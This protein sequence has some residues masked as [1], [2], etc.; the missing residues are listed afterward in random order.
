MGNDRAV[1]AKYEMI[2]NNV[3]THNYAAKMVKRLHTYIVITIAPDCLSS[4][5]SSRGWQTQ[6]C[7]R[8]EECLDESLAV[9]ANS[10]MVADKIPANLYRRDAY[11]S[12]YPEIQ[13]SRL[14]K[15]L[16]CM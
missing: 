4:V 3:F 8:L 13:A 7:H 9:T 12:C 10:E 1:G 5:L 15:T 2:D 16:K 14:F 6:I 11:T